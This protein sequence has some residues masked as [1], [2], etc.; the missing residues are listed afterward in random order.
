MRKKSSY[1]FTPV[2]PIILGQK[3][4]YSHVFDLECMVLSAGEHFHTN[5]QTFIPSEDLKKSLQE[6]TN[7]LVLLF[8][9][10]RRQS[11]PPFFSNQDV[12]VTLTL[13]IM[14]RIATLS[15]C[16]SLSFFLIFSLQ[17]FSM[18]VWVFSCFD[19]FYFLFLLNGWMEP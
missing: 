16:F 18:L 11:F 15:V 5:R 19:C 7:L 14:I 8:L 12:I 17:F 2:S 13:T 4:V 10:C 9:S 6:A 3:V 1:L